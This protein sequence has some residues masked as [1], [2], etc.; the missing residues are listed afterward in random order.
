MKI[1]ALGLIF[2]ASLSLSVQSSY[3]QGLAVKARPGASQSISTLRAQ[4]AASAAVRVQGRAGA[5]SS[6]NG[7]LV[8]VANNLQQTFAAPGA[9][10][11]RAQA[12]RASASV[13]NARSAGDCENEA[14]RHCHGNAISN[15]PKSSYNNSNGQC[16]LT[17]A[18]TVDNTTYDVCVKWSGEGFNG[19]CE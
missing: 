15:C 17:F 19:A 16:T 4:S 6:S 2:G 1:G 5:I 11:A 9:R 3:G 18:N 13:V 7:S 10:G 8:P 14:K 12:Q